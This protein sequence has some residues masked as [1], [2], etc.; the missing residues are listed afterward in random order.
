MEK[1]SGKDES[2]AGGWTLWHF[3]A[4][5]GRGSLHQPRGPSTCNGLP[6]PPTRL[7]E[8]DSNLI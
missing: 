6:L 8:G 3:Q 4:L 7:M 5:W 1:G 2:D